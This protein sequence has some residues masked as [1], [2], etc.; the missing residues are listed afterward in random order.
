M[1]V[2]SDSEIEI[3]LL[4]EAIFYKYNYDFRD[5]S[6]ASVNRRL[7]LALERLNCNTISSLQERVIHDPEFFGQLLQFLTVPTSEMF[8]DPSHFK[9]I[10]EKVVPILETYPSFKLWIAGC[11][12][13]E[14]VY[15][16]SILLREENI[17]DRAI[18]YATDI[19]QKNLE[20]AKLG[21]FPSDSLPL[22]RSNYHESGGRFDFSQYFT[23]AYSGIKMDQSLIQ[24]VVFADHSLA[25]DS[26]FSEVNYISCRNVMIYFNRILQDRALGL[27]HDSLCYR[28]FLGIGSK[29][30]IQFSKYSN[31]FDPFVKLEKIY[32]KTSA[33]P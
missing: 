3:K 11:S 4:L 13:G 16:F 32:R 29:E 8:R 12:T 19:N 22:F 20:K 28:G 26:V 23:Q 25:T 10:R 18:I 1:G 6:M 7:K 5:F 2:M 9:A 21:I 17:S 14:E 15:T 31:A 27:F 30:S 33:N 24:N